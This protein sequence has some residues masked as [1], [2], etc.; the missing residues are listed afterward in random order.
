MFILHHIKQPIKQY[1]H[2]NINNMTQSIDE[3]HLLTVNVGLAQHYADW[4]WKNVNSPFVRLYYVTKGH[5]RIILPDGIQELTP[6]H[7]YVIP[8]FTVH[9]YSC[10]EYFEHYYIH[11]YEDVQN[12]SGLLDDFIFPTELPAK[13]MELLLF[14]RLCEINPS[15]KLLQSNPTT[16]DNNSILVQNIVKNKQRT[17]CDRVESRGIIYQLI[18]RFLKYAKLRTEACDTRIQK[19]LTY[20]R[21]HISQS[22]TVD[23]LAEQICIS[24]DH[25]IRLFKKEI[26]I[27]PVQYINQKKIEKAQLLLATEK[28]SV[29]EIAFMLSFSDYTYFNRLFKRYT[30]VSP[31]EYKKSV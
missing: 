12:G 7:I 24:K 1:L 18:A 30:G 31:Q 20:I 17:L 22:L 5:A 23:L 8:A 27:T 6:N 29:K 19:T 16:Y 10:D 2:H 9:S 26:G 14:Q 28:L 4:N 3:L 11:I 15:M 21:K 13:E 25:F